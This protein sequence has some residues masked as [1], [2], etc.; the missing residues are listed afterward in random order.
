[1][2]R[3][4]SETIG[5]ILFVAGVVITFIGALWAGNYIA[6]EFIFDTKPTWDSIWM[7]DGF[8]YGVYFTILGIFIL[9]SWIVFT[10]KKSKMV[11]C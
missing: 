5:T 3:L 8:K 11:N 6:T 10:I 1:M 2:A 7:D 9:L 4:Q